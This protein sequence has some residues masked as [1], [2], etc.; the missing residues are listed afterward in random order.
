VR[1]GLNEIGLV[2]TSPYVHIIGIV[3]NAND[4][5]YIP[6]GTMCTIG[7]RID[8]NG[9]SITVGNADL[10]STINHKGFSIHGKTSN[11]LLHAA[12]GTIPI[13]EIQNQVIASIID[14]APE[15]LDTLNELAAALG[16]DPNF[17]TTIASQLG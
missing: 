4:P 8:N 2:P 13:S 15:T 17:A 3:N 6:Y 11:D 9:G 10:P 16:D 14:E 1:K 5:D 12:G 7:L